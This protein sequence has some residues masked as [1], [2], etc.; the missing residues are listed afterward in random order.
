MAKKVTKKPRRDNKPSNKPKKVD[1]PA[2][3][4]V[5]IYKPNMKVQ[6]VAEG[7]GVS[8]AI[9]IK[10]LMQLGIMA[11]VNIDLDRETIELIALEL[12][13]EIK[14][15]VITDV[16]RYDEFEIVDKEE[17]LVGRPA[18]VTVMGHVDH[19]KT[20]LLDTIR[21]S[22]VTAGEAGG[23]TQ[24]IGAYQVD[25]NGKKITF[26]DTP[27]HAA[28]TEM[29]VRGAK[30]TDIVVLV[31]AADDGV[32]PQTLEALDHAKA[33][34][35]KIIV[36]VN[37]MD[38]PTANPDQ[39]MSE[40]A[41]YGLMAEE[42]G[43]DTPYV[44]ISAL[45][46]EGIDELLDLIEL[47]S[48]IED[49][50]AN[51]NR[52]ATGSVIEAK[53]D[54]GRGPVATLI[55]SNGTLKVGDNIVVGNTY[56]KIRTMENDLKERFDI[57]SPSTAIEVTG[58]ND[59]PQAGDTFMVFESERLT[60]QIAEERQALIRVGEQK[61]KKA[62]LESMFGDGDANK[63]L[64]ILI[65]ADFQGSIEALKNLLE[66]ID[67]DGFHANIVRA[68]VGGITE[69]DVTLASASNAIIIGFNV[70]PT[71]NV[72]DVSEEQGVEIRLYSVIYRIA[73]DLEKAL[74]GML[75][76]KFEEKITGQVEVRETFKVSKIG[77]IAG[78]YVTDGVIKRNALV[79]LIRDGIV[80]Y[81]GK[82]ASLK[83]FKD[84][85]KEVR[86]GFECGLS[87]VNY[88]DLK[89]GDIIEASELQEVE[90]E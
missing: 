36:A 8:N 47:I 53:L 7:L 22:R 21:K 49:Y 86:T 31:V 88:N 66:T 26:I 39:I 12:G 11:S 28:F 10:Q 17:D 18:I 90:V 35:T 2:G 40:L 52:E 38:K 5:L 14:D 1:K 6:D 27:G 60:R 68:S 87:I 16:V 57:A 76:P 78:C 19:G 43:G 25:R 58:L 77:T 67:I 65:K 79:K 63:E 55:V 45:K 34:N 73:E 72:R 24:H 46:K 81:E 32:M 41:N 64:N 62:T 75:E 85:V 33:A 30:V 84:D 23:I 74:K 56:G 71:G 50:K 4:K 61:Q 59:V 70:R 83:R 20:T 80:I 69:N 13:Y 48:E 37:K 9:V 44:K 54:R 89:V 3:E 42:W 51:P 15:E 29:R 82:L